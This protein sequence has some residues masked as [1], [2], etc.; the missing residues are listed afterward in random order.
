MI[1]AVEF[2]HDWPENAGPRRRDREGDAQP[3][4]TATMSHVE[5]FNEHVWYDPHTIAHARR[6]DRRTSSSELQPG[7]RRH[8]RGERRGL[9]RRH[10]RP[11]GSARRRSTRRTPASKV[12]VTEPVPLYLVTAAG[13]GQRDPRRVQRG[14]RG[15]SG[16][17]RPR[18][19]STRSTL[20][21]SGDVSVVIVNAQTGGAETTAGDRRG[22]R[23]RR[24][25]CIE[26]T[27][28]LPDGQTYLSWMTAN[29]EALA[30]AL[31][32]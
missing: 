3:T 29:I 5:G 22:R 11:R 25:R 20:L 14:G 21:R 18:P 31:A 2:S 30:G 16:C 7:A 6:R 19:C 4:S 17:R 13:L 1:T 24:S 27:E 32:K 12:F 15:R 26:F 10:R 23:R 28:T 9:R 8:V